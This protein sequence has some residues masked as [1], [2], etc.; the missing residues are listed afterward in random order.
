[1]RVRS[2]YNAMP[3]MACGMVMRTR[4]HYVAWAV[5]ARVSLP[6]PTNPTFRC[7]LAPLCDRALIVGFSIEPREAR[8]PKGQR[9]RSA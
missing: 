2:M 5:R 1:M 9:G 7:V 6:R 4:L 8:R 3:V